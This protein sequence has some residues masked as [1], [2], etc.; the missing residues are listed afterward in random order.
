M[1]TQQSNLSNEIGYVTKSQDYLVFIQG[2]PSVKVNDILVTKNGGRALVNA[3]EQDTIEVLMLDAERPKPGDSLTFSSTGIKLPLKANM[4]GRT[5]DPLGVAADG[6]EALPPGDV[7]IDLDLVA[8]GIDKREV[9]NEQF[10]TGIT[11][12]DTLVPIGRG[13]RELIYGEPRSG[14]TAFLQDV[15]IHQ[16]E[17]GTI[18]VYCA[19]GRSDIEVKRFAET[20]E[21]QGASG[22]TI[23]VAATSSD[24]A[25]MI[26]IAPAIA[27]SVAEFFRDQGKDV[28]LVFDD[29]ATH[30]KYLREISLLAGRTPGRESY[31]ADIF[32]Q[33]SHLVERGGRFNKQVGGGS[34][35]M[36]PVIQTDLENFDSLIPTNVMS[37]TDGHTLFTAALRA[38][39]RYPAV[40]E[41]RS[42]TRVGRQTQLRI[43]NSL[44]DKLRGL[45]AD[46]HEL[47][48][49]ARFGSELSVTTQQTIKRG[50][51]AEELLRQDP[52]SYIQPGVQMMMLGLVF[53]GYFD[54]K[55]IDSI[56]LKRNN[57]VGVLT[58]DSTFSNLASRV[59]K[60]KLDELFAE[61]PR[62]HSIV[63]TAV[64]V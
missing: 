16:K 6:K 4:F 45:L 44:A 38:Q 50:K 12:I 42:V 22:H 18:C 64:G 23:M 19:I 8:P 3:L 37:M 59:P 32:Y 47:E 5:V 58:N 62:Y 49:Y 54:A 29:L 24:S 1:P 51:V 52:L 25:P 56:R 33:H 2:L 17:T 21:K 35:T 46:Y 9:I 10:Y 27:S 55:D 31:P 30:S 48:R 20:I 41:D 28:L 63:D 43:H 26:A 7:E 60:M 15:I 57:I 14:R 53:T 36:L 61:L 39:G 40:D 34:I 11:L 13:Q